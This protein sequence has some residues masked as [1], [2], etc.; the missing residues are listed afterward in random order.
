MR[1]RSLIGIMDFHGS[2]RM[3]CWIICLVLSTARASTKEAPELLVVDSLNDPL[4]DTPSSGNSSPAAPE[5]IRILTNDTDPGDV[6]LQ[7]EETLSAR[8]PEISDT[9]IEE[10][11]N[12]GKDRAE[13]LF[14]VLLT[15]DNDPGFSKRALG[16]VPAKQ[17]IVNQFPAVDNVSSAAGLGRFGEMD[18]RIIP[19]S[20]RANMLLDVTRGV[21]DKK[22]EHVRAIR[23]ITG[24][25]LPQFRAFCPFP[26][27]KAVVSL[28]TPF[29]KHN[30]PQCAGNKFRSLDGSCNNVAFLTRGKESTIYRR[31][32]AAN[33][34]DGISEMR[35]PSVGASLP[36]A[37]AISIRVFD[38]A[39]NPEGDISAMSAH[40]GQFLAHEIVN[41]PSS[42]TVDKQ[43]PKCCNS[44]VTTHPDCWPINIPND[45]TFS[46]RHG[47]TCMEFVRT[48]PGIRPGCTLGPREQINQVTHFIDGSSVYGST[49]EEAANLRLFVKGQLK[50]TQPYWQSP[51]YTL[52]PTD[53]GGCPSHPTGLQCFKGGDKRV[54]VQP[55]L[56]M[57]HTI[58]MRHHN[59]LAS[60]L[61]TINPHWDDERLFQETRRIVGA[62]LQH[63]VFQE[64]L[65]LI[66]GSSLMHS[67]NISL[68]DGQNHPPYDIT[69]NPSITSEFAVAA[70]RLHSTIPPIIALRNADFTRAGSKRFREAWFSP[71][72]LYQ[73]YYMT[74]C[75]AGMASGVWDKMDQHFTTETQNHLFQTF[76]SQFGLD[77]PAIDIQRGRDH[78]LQPYVKYRELCQLRVPKN[79]LDLKRM[80][81][82]PEPVVDRLA[83]V[84]NSV[85]DIDLFVGGTVENHVANGRVG[86]TFACI[87]GEQFYRLRYGDRFWYDNKVPLPSAFTPE[88]V[89]Q[90]KKTSLSRIL[91]SNVDGLV[92]IQR[93]IFRIADVTKNPRVAC[94]A[95]PEVDWQRWKENI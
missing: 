95:L 72:D 26:K 66:L 88:H 78:G 67:F 70:F 21:K 61:S 73:G 12:K 64:Y 15:D 14:G 34:G 71:F 55:G 18:P 4:E 65:P 44:P 85:E 54:N 28:T 35:T 80:R 8:Y 32:L 1:C 81:I 90:I 33:Y 45:D 68:D 77:L 41:S 83:K 50:T 24:L 3:I 31:L 5:I 7:D 6:G 56:T 23:Q 27:E 60:L 49:N 46:A 20:Q 17:L 22:D 74:Q 19:I 63:I 93:D 92:N 51:Q 39:E 37:R 52:L 9:F 11:I 94:T 82:M 42:K 62:Q 84:Y 10:L 43:T 75:A 58:F 87:I 2:C 36:S 13:G 30:L 25:T 79:F 57:L 40:F 29:D 69:I 91:C 48:L 59:N 53:A 16:K 86:P 76:P 89:E 38:N 47:R